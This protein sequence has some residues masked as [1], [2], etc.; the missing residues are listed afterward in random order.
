MI[1]F[2]FLLIF[3]IITVLTV[4]HEFG[5]FIVARF[6][7]VSVRIFSVGFGKILLKKRISGTEY[8][9]SA[10]PFGGYVIMD[11]NETE[12][13]LPSLYPGAMFSEKP[14][15]QRMLIVL[16]GP[17][18]NFFLAFF[19]LF[20]L[21]LQYGVQTVF[22]RIGEMA[23]GLLITASGGIAEV[24]SA[25]AFASIGLGFLNLFPISNS[26]GRKILLFLRES[27]CRKPFPKS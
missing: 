21:A 17:F 24:L 7:G 8:A 25:A 9:L 3:G 22:L 12:G 14:A 4:V 18:F 15:W 27:I 11:V 19:V 10:I 23:H 26:D 1:L 20:G 16:A 13:V 2:G 6:F 5:H